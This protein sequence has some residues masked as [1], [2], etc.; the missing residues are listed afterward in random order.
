MR[1]SL[2]I[3]QGTYKVTVGKY[4]GTI[5]VI[6]RPDTLTDALEHMYSSVIV[7]ETG[8]IRYQK[9]SVQ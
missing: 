1:S 3:F 7:H 8:L 9:D 6:E 4:F 5:I 2:M